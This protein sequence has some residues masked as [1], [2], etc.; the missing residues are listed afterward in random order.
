MSQLNNIQYKLSKGVNAWLEYE[1][2]CDRGN[3]FNEKYLSYPI[4]NILNNVTDCLVLTELNHPSVSKL[5]VG[6]PLQIDF[7]LSEKTNKR[8]WQFAIESKWTGITK[9]KFED[10]IWDLIRLQNIF[11]ILPNIKCYF[12]FSGF[13]KTLRESKIDILFKVPNDI[14]HKNKKSLI[15]RK[16]SNFNFELKYLDKTTKKNINKKNKEY[17]DFKLYSEIAIRPP[18]VFPIFDLNDLSKSKGVKNMSL[19]TCAF[20]I[21]KPNQN[22]GIPKI[23]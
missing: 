15:K 16:R 7:V 9:P 4:G 14:E 2:A 1:F 19:F 22:K 5:K 17:E 12:V 21:L 6:R 3:L 18:H 20:E 8:N 11:N 13:I 10:I 23:E